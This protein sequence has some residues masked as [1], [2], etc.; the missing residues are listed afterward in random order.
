MRI[1]HRVLPILLMVFGFAFFSWNAVS[2]FQ[3]Y[4]ASI[5]PIETDVEFN[6]TRLSPVSTGKNIS[7]KTV[8]LYPSQPSVGG[9]IGILTIPKL[10][11]SFPVFEGTSEEILKKGAGH[12][13]GSALPGERNNSIISGHRDTI[14]RGLRHLKIKDNLI[15]QTDAGSFLYKIRKIRIVDADDRTVMTP[16]PRGTLTVT[17]CYPFYFI[18]DAPQRYVIVADLISSKV[19]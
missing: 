10:N 17:T 13:Q 8:S 15:V 1:N 11:E 16:K 7:K 12:L 6:N 18:G 2:F 4:Y 5:D 19:N 9:R 14:F 3:G